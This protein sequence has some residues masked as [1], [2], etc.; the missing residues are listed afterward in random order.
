MF[1]LEFFCEGELHCLI[2][3]LSQYGGQIAQGVTSL[4]GGIV[5]ANRLRKKPGGTQPFG[6]HAELVHRFF[7]IQSLW[8]FKIDKA[9][10]NQIDADV[11]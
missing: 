6:Q 7:V 11:G 1:A 3:G 8:L 9:F 10:F 4:F 2:T 5:T